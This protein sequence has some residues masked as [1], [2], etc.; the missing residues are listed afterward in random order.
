MLI[1][2]SSLHCPTLSTFV[3]FDLKQVRNNNNAGHPPGLANLL[4]LVE[5]CK[6]GV[7]IYGKKINKKYFSNI[8][9]GRMHI[10]L[11]L[12]QLSLPGQSGC[13]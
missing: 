4:R 3:L 10:L 6:I 1:Y 5:T 13:L 12:I 8:T 9:A 11:A 7:K 2:H